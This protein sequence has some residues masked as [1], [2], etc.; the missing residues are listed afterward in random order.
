MIVPTSCVIVQMKLDNKCKVAQCL[1]QN[2]FHKCKMLL[3][4]MLLMK[5]LIILAIDQ[6]PEK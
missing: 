4:Q 5:S 2:T 3:S 6:R 1:A